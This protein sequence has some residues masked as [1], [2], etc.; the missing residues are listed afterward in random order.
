VAFRRALGKEGGDGGL[1][2]GF[3]AGC[4][5]WHESPDCLD[6]SRADPAVA[7]NK[8]KLKC[9]SRGGD[10]TIWHIWDVDTR[11]MLDGARD[12]KVE[13]DKAEW[14]TPQFEYGVQLCQDCCRHSPL[15]NKIAQLDKADRRNEDQISSIYRVVEGLFGRL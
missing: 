15:L 13:C 9:M 3:K 2:G 6:C 1:V 10:D 4:R 12:S 14:C 7:R 11:N 8:R 5:N